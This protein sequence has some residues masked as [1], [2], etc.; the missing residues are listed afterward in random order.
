M[1]SEGDPVAVGP[2]DPILLGALLAVSLG[3]LLGSV[4][5]RDYIRAVIAFAAGSAVLAA[6]FALFGATFVAV[7]ELTV[8]AGVVAVLFLVSITMTEGRESGE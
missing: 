1:P 4:F 8:G 6:V 7:L 3:A 5:L 2:P